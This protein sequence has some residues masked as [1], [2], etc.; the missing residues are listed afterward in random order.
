MTVK[1]LRK[2]RNIFFPGSVAYWE[3]RYR[4]NG[5]SGVGSYGEKARYKAAYLNKFVSENH[6]SRVIEF[7]CGDGNQLKQFQFPYYLGL[8]ISPTAVQIC[9]KIFQED[10]TKKFFIYDQKVL[11]ESAMAF[12]AELSL[13]LDVIFHLVEDKIFENY[14]FDL[15]KASTKYVVI[16][17]WDVEEEKKFHI[18]HR[19]FTRWINNNIPEFKLTERI[20]SKGEGNFCDFFIYKRLETEG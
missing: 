6:I 12:N 4:K 15:F 8:D 16:Y 1:L 5:N 10:K 13:S 7:G 17:A 3:R 18:R 20:I 19:H 9:S 2:I 14:M 11:S